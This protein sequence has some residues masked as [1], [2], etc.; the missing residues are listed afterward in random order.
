[1]NE[2]LIISLSPYWEKIISYYYDQI[3]NGDDGD[4]VE[5]RPSIWEWLEQ[6]FN[7]IRYHRW[8]RTNNKIS[9]VIFETEAE[10][11]FFKLRWT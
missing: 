10:L 6:E 4:D 9:D 3:E 7:A 5:D 11:V 2:E 1:M 8:H